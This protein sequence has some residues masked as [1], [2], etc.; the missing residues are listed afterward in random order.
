M[1]WRFDDGPVEAR[2]RAVLADGNAY[3]GA[4]T[5]TDGSC[6]QL[7][8]QCP[9]SDGTTPQRLLLVFARD[10]E[11]RRLREENRNLQASLRDVVAGSPRPVLL[12]DADLT[13]VAAS[14]AFHDLFE[15]RADAVLGAPLA[16]I[17]G[18]LFDEAEIRAG[19]AALRAGHRTKVRTAFGFLDAHG[20]RR[21]IAIE[22]RRIGTATAAA[23][24]FNVYDEARPEGGLGAGLDMLDQVPEALLV[25]DREER[26]RFA[27]TAAGT[28]FGAPA[29]ALEG[30]Y[31]AALVPAAGRDDGLRG[32][33]LDVFAEPR[34][35]RVAAVP[36]LA[37]GGG[38]TAEMALDLTLSPLAFDGLD[39]TLLLVQPPGAATSAAPEPARILVE[40]ANVACVLL[41]RNG[42]VRY[43]NAHA[44]SLAGRQRREVEGE[45]WFRLF[46][47]ANARGRLR[48]RF[49][50]AVARNEMLEPNN[51]E[52][53]VRGH[54]GERRLIAWHGVAIRDEAGEITNLGLTGLDITEQRRARLALEADRAQA[55]DANAL[56]SRV[57]AATGRDLQQPLQTLSFLHGVLERRITD[58]AGREVL[59][60]LG[61]V[62]AAMSSTV[63]VLL[64]IGR[65]DELPEEA[66]LGDIALGEILTDVRTRF[67]DAAAAKGLELRVVA[68]TL[69]VRTDRALVERLLHELV[70]NAVRYTETGTVLVGCRRR[71]AEVRLV[72]ADSRATL[73]VEQLRLVAEQLHGAADG[74]TASYRPSAS[75]INVVRPLSRLPEHRLEVGFTL[76]RGA[77][78]G[79]RMPRSIAATPPAREA[80][81]WRACDVQ[82]LVVA[83]ERSVRD[84][85]EQLF[86]L[87]GFEVRLARTVGEGLALLAEDEAIPDLIV[88]DQTA[89]GPAA[90]LRMVRGLQARCGRPVPAVVLVNEPLS[91]PAETLA[92]EGIHPL[93]KPV[94]VERLLA[95]TGELVRP[96]RPADPAVEGAG[97]TVAPGDTVGVVCP[98]PDRREAYAAALHE[99]GQAVVV[100]QDL[101][102][103]AAATRDDPPGCLV[104]DPG[105]AARR[106]WLETMEQA[107]QRFEAPVVVLS[108]RTD[109]SIA[110]SVMRA[111]AF[112]FLAKPV[113]DDVL[114]DTVA[115]ALRESRKRRREDDD[116]L[117]AYSRFGQL[118]PRERQVLRLLIAGYSNKAV[119]AELQIS[120]R[121]AENHRARIMDKTEARSLAD[122]VRL[123]ALVDPEN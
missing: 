108:D 46:V 41:D 115:L 61:G 87:E 112:E 76:G 89:A 117:V 21:S 78:F 27:N 92:A 31:L 85:V 110:V 28:L 45:D 123:A 86:V 66:R 59:A 121:T 74:A 52:Y 101:A 113:R 77:M 94:T 16:E 30:T 54:D 47:P 80:L 38:E 9:G 100:A 8:A 43:V 14:D 79:I 64:N 82:A 26:I 7:S 29:A 91:A 105:A 22:S 84:S 19:L 81:P 56:K 20:H 51:F 42:H 65:L 15:T 40:N 106:Q 70:A 109:V 34:R 69:V 88:A 97:L 83:D 102:T 13:V 18:G 4:V 49:E 33:R 35:R 53:P 60:T 90:A 36:G 25:V 6:W 72:V 32:H 73:P 67:A 116:A 12:L 17:V 57:L 2:A 95:L 122:L 5:C 68:T 93:R 107:A 98:D 58:A 39:A 44:L 118:T 119:A 55:D 1:A 75:P 23:I 37:V 50:Q 24:L 114:R 71:A 3:R 62:I 111:G 99:V 103:L 11:G 48:D 104:L 120:P 96:P 10:R 63:E